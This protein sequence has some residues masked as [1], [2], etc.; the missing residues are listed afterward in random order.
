MSGTTTREMFSSSGA[1]LRAVPG[2]EMSETTAKVIEEILAGD[3]LSSPEA[4]KLIPPFRG[5]ALIANSTYVR[6]IQAGV[7]RP[8]GTVVKLGAVRWGNRWITSRPA[9]VRFI[10]A[11]TSTS[12]P[13]AGTFTSAAGTAVNPKRAKAADD[14]LAQAGA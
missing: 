2:E 9:I 7:T 4:R 11:L 6:F 13:T 3:G 1:P 12:L 8:D 5:A 14:K 10:T